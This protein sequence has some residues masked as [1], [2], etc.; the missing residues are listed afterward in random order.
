MT[1]FDLRTFVL[2]GLA[3]L[4]G[5]LVGFT[6]HE[7]AHAL[8]AYAL[9][10]RGEHTRR[11]LTLNPLRHVSW[12]GLAAFLIVRIGWAKPV[13]FDP[14]QFKHPNLDSFL[15]AIA[16]VTANFLV[17]VLWSLVL[18][19]GLLL[20][21]AVLVLAD[22]SAVEMQ[23]WLLTTEARP[24][25]L[26]I[27]AF[28]FDIV[29]VNLVLAGFNLLPIPG[30]DGF[31]A[32]LRLMLMVRGLFRRGA[33]PS[34]LDAAWTAPAAGPDQPDTAIPL[35]GTPAD[36][37]QQAR[38]YQRRGLLREAV[39]AYRAALSQDPTNL[40]A[41]QGLAQA[42]RMLGEHRQA[43]AALGAAL[44]QPLEPAARESLTSAM[45]ELGWRAGDPVP[46]LEP[47]LTTG[48]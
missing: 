15:V 27:G 41:Y 5:L 33:P 16:G 3:L 48:S 21:A 19:V 18:A 31:H 36:L 29:W 32:L 14:R 20:T 28:T 10:D 47:P 26:L 1:G 39:A 25:L 45:R 6:V 40:E 30:L 2:E 8:V 44:S 42:H 43:I 35:A 11:R 7:L 13:R 46:A 17:A 37:L 34:W 22:V 9:G 24:W 12:L 23:R 4:P 38:T